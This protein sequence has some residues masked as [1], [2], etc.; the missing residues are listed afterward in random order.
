MCVLWEVGYKPG[1]KGPLGRG[2]KVHMTEANLSCGAGGGA[3]LSFTSLVEGASGT[4]RLVF[5]SE[6]RH[7]RGGI[8]GCTILGS[9]DR[10]PDPGRI[11]T[12]PAL[13]N[14]LSQVAT[15]ASEIYTDGSFSRTSRA[16]GFYS[17][18]TDSKSGAGIAFYLPDAN[19]FHK[20]HIKGDLSLSNSYMTEMVALA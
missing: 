15:I 6:E 14:E 3:A 1:S 11:W 10:F 17:G 7:Y 19:E 20:V 5:L 8:T 18:L 9:R 12:P 2:G 16:A 13:L 4:R